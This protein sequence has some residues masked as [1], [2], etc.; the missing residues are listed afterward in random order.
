MRHTIRVMNATPILE[1]LPTHS[2]TCESRSDQVTEFAAVRS[3]LLGIASRVLG[4]STD[5]ED[6]VQDAWL[7]WQS[8]DR[9]K[10]VDPT[11]F[12]VTTTARLAI[13]AKQS[14]HARREFAA[15]ECVN[16]RLDMSD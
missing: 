5:A 7:R 3:R 13:N 1:P 4:R 10:V 8:Y 6:I 2:H 12:L 15:D 9:A 14:A 11:A 16:E